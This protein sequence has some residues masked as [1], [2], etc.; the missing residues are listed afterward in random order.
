MIDG[1]QIRIGGEDY[2]IPPLNFK[3]LKALKSKLDFKTEPGAL[4]SDEQMDA[5]I[6]VIHAAMSRNYPQY[7]KEQVEEMIDLGNMNAVFSAVMNSSG[8]VKKPGEE[9]GPESR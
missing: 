2:V 5:M 7:T 3:Q 9:K 6:E 4:I 1:V 8:L